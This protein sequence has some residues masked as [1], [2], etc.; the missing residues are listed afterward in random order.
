MRGAAGTL[1]RSAMSVLALWTAVQTVLLIIAVIIV[2]VLVVLM[3]TAKSE[4][5]ES[6]PEERSGKEGTSEKKK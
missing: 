6:G 2:I 4:P 3:S 5:Q 1:R